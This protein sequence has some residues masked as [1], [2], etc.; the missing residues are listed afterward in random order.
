MYISNPPDF[1]DRMRQAPSYQ[2]LTP[3][4]P[5]SILDS[6]PAFIYILDLVSHKLTYASPYAQQLF[7]I[8]NNELLSSGES[9]LRE[10]C[11]EEDL[12]NMTAAKSK[13]MEAAAALP[14]GQRK[15]IRC[16]INYRIARKCGRVLAVQEHLSITETDSK[17]NPLQVIGHICE[18]PVMKSSFEFAYFIMVLD[19]QKGWIKRLCDADAAV[20][21]LSKRELEILKLLAKGK[22]SKI[23]ADELKISINT[24]NNHRKNML[25]K[26]S[27]NNIAELVKFAISQG[28]I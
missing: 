24:V 18:S 4:L 19:P 23:I 28:L 6:V 12:E 13:F 20:C 16:T 3:L 2:L 9:L 8:S 26:A 5:E 1:H 21:N 25:L 27:C 7:G 15:K 10:M 14:A 22:S 17:G 11:F